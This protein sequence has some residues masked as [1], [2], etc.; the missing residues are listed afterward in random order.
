MKPNLF[1]KTSRYRPIE[2]MHVEGR[3]DSAASGLIV[4]LLS[5]EGQMALRVP[6]RSRAVKTLDELAA[7]KG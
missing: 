6:K 7:T 1:R 4:Y 5:G 3:A 2:L